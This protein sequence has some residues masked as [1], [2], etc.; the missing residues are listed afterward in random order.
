MKLNH[1]F[2]DFRAA[3]GQAE[4]FMVQGSRLKTEKI[5]EMS[6]KLSPGQF[7]QGRN[8][9]GCTSDCSLALR[10]AAEG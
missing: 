7:D 1:K 4:R 6:R 8:F 9:R 2:S 5:T 10:G 3:A